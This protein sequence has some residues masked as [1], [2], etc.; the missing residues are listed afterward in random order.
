VEGHRFEDYAGAIRNLSRAGSFPAELVRQLERL[1]GFRNVVIHEYV[2]L[3]LDRVVD[4]LRQLE[5]IER[6]AEIVRLM[7]SE[8]E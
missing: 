6:F 4:A 8:A 7:E 1:P 2:S 5:P 3:D